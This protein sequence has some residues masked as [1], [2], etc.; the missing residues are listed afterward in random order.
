MTK[1]N[2]TLAFALLFCFSNLTLGDQNHNPELLIKGEQG[3]DNFVI[4]GDGNWQAINGAIQA[5]KSEGSSTF[6]VTKKS[7]DNFSLEIEFWASDDANS[8]IFMRCQDIDNITDKNCYEA[9]IYDTR[10]EQNYATGAI[11]HVA[12][13]PVPAIKV[14]GKWNTY[15]ITLNGNH[16]TVILNGVKTVDVENSTLSSGPI[17]LQCG[18]GTLKFRKFKITELK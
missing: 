4:I 17:G 18:K 11:V 12:E 2:K 14:G 5:K 7:Y 10:P 3:L 13:A 15:K 8:G 1:L 16:L 9:N 6:L